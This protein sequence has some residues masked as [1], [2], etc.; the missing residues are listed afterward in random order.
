[1]LLDFGIMEERWGSVNAN[2][3]STLQLLVHDCQL[4]RRESLPHTT[5]T[6]LTLTRL[7]FCTTNGVTLAG[8]ENLI[9]FK[10][11]SREATTTAGWLACSLY[12]LI[13]LL[14]LWVFLLI[15]AF[16]T[17]SIMLPDFYLVS[18]LF[19]EA[20]ART[21]VLLYV[22]GVAYH[23]RLQW[24]GRVWLLIRQKHI[25]IRARTRERE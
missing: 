14:P 10:P 21:R 17:F 6:T 4:F 25:R 15:I 1:M 2:S 9:F 16:F 8:G 7:G 12:L 13:F 22:A 18:S 23:F 24:R 19:I 3:S 20:M 5:K 11:L